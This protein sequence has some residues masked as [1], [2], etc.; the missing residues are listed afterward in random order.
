MVYEIDPLHDERW[1]PFLENHRL[2]SVFHGPEWLSALQQTSGYKVGAFTTCGPGE[3]LTNAV[4]FCRVRSWLT[5]PRLVSLPFSDH[6]APLFE[7]EEQLD[8]LL[9]QLKQ[10]CDRETEQYFEIRSAAEGARGMANSASFCLHRIDLRPNLTELFDGL[11]ESCVRRKIARAQREGVAYE[12]GTSEEILSEFYRMMVLTR[13]RHSVPPQPLAWFRSL[14]SCM[15]DRVKIR[16]AS[17]KGQRAAGILTLRYKATMTYKYGCS[18]SQFHRF[19]PMQFLMW[20]AIQEAKSDGLVEFDL[21]RTDLSNEG[22]LTFKDHWGGARST[23][24]YMRYPEP[25]IQ[26][27]TESAALQ[28]AQSLVPL[29][30]A[31]LL[32]KAGNIIYQHID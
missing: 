2:A 20:K 18:E 3:A 4:V 21:G 24:T 22:L 5:G 1:A 28:V 12:E 29:T 9:C 10:Q 27:T 23:L 6:C 19:G 31:R 14:I 17:Y 13:R 16:L 8:L 25:R 26:R 7:T 15:G 11:H 32:A 30:P